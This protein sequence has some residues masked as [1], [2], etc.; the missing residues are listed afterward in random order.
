MGTPFHG[1]MFI[2]KVD[3]ECLDHVVMSTALAIIRGAIEFSPTEW[4]LANRRDLS[5]YGVCPKDWSMTALHLEAIESREKLLEHMR[6]VEQMALLETK[7]RIVEGH[8][9]EA[10]DLSSVL[11]ESVK[12]LNLMW[13][14]LYES[15]LPRRGR[16]GEISRWTLS[17]TILHTVRQQC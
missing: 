7:Q 17:A 13:T 12:T 2:A 14:A 9:R 6:E 8:H 1:G 5:T 3:V 16:I 15:D 4:R 11:E 10:N